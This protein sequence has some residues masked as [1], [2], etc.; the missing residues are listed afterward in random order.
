MI[1]TKKKKS[2]RISLGF[3]F[4]VCFVCLDFV[5]DLNKKTYIRKKNTFDFRSHSISRCLFVVILIVTANIIQ[6]CLLINDLYGCWWMLVYGWYS[7]VYFSVWWYSII[8]FWCNHYRL[9]NAS[10]LETNRI[11]FES[12]RDEDRAFERIIIQRWGFWWWNFLITSF[13][14]SCIST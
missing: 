6:I 10:L 8:I 12:I 11:R 5:S 3:C 9:V 7:I 14:F 2:D 1:S 4:F 13:F